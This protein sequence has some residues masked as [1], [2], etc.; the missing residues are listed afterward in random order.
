MIQII[1]G[2]FTGIVL[3]VLSGVVLFWIISSHSQTYIDS[4]PFILLYPILLAAT[5][6]AVSSYKFRTHLFSIS[7]FIGVIVSILV[8][9]FLIRGA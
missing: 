5:A 8:I 2:T 7:L 4:A 6:A 3:E 9:I 1:F